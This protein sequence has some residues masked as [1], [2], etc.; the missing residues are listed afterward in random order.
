MKYIFILVCLFSV[1]AYADNSSKMIATPDPKIMEMWKQAST[2]GE[3]HKL[4]QRYVGKWNHTVSF[5]MDADAKPESSKGTSEVESILGGRFI[6]HKVLGTS[7]GQPFEGLGITGYDNVRKHF[8]TYWIDNM[9][10]GAMIGTGKYDKAQNVIHDQGTFTCP[11][12]QSGTRPYRVVWTLPEKDSFK[13]EM[14]S[15]GEDE[16]EFRM[17]EIVYTRAR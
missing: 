6:R 8:S 10:T 12:Y 16:K 3:E 7:M 9:G 13:Y 11:M 5:W 1:T 15:V 2:P 4:L 17:M 14:Y